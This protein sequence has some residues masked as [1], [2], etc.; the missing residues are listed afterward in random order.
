MKSALIAPKGICL[1][2]EQVQRYIKQNQQEKGSRDEG[3]EPQQWME[4]GWDG[5]I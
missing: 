5:E 4:V 1:T 3:N 2:H